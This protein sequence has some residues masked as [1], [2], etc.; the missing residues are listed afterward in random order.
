MTVFGLML[1]FAAQSKVEDRRSQSNSWLM[2]HFVQRALMGPAHF[3][4]SVLSNTR[5]LGSLLILER[6]QFIVLAG[7]VEHPI[8]ADCIDPAPIRPDV[9][10]PVRADGRAAFHE[11]PIACRWAVFRLRFPE[12]KCVVTVVRFGA[13]S[14]QKSYNPGVFQLNDPQRQEL[15]QETQN[16]TGS[17]KTYGKPQT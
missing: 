1:I 11:R 4:A 3:L 2:P 10:C 8:R 12:M 7:D 15:V 13:E 9:H 5:V 16:A 17:K 6:V 14:R